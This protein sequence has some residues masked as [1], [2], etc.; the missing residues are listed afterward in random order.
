MSAYLNKS[1][2]V[3]S[4]LPSFVAIILVLQVALYLS[5]FFAFQLLGKSSVLS[6]LTFIPGFVIVKLLKQDNLGLAETVLFSVGLSV[7][8]VMLA[9]LVVNEVGLLVGIR[10]P[11][12][13]SLLVLV[14]SGFVLLGALACYFRGSQDLQPVGL[15]KGTVVKFFVLCSLP[16]LSI[17]GAY[18]ANVTGNTFVLLLALSAILAVFMASGFF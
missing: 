12:E 5:F 6:T 13:P 16:V 8:F 2:A 14:L 11:L 18:F 17:V 1:S 7:A 9:G 4:K 15:T 10:Q 3:L